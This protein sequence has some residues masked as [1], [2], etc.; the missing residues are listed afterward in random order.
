MVSLFCFSSEK[1][2]AATQD[3]N[4]DDGSNQSSVT[5]NTDRPDYVLEDSQM[6]Q[7][8]IPSNIPAVWHPAPDTIT[9][10]ALEKS[11]P[12]NK[13]PKIPDGS[14]SENTEF[15]DT[16]TVDGEKLIVHS[17][18]VKRKRKR[19]PMYIPNSQRHKASETISNE[20]TESEENYYKF[21][22]H[23]PAPSKLVEAEENNYMID[24]NVITPSAELDSSFGRPEEMSIKTEPTDEPISECTETLPVEDPSSTNDGISQYDLALFAQDKSFQPSF[25]S[26]LNSVI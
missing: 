8:D 19:K 14:A 15:S 21:S 7:N 6:S 26:K 22:E 20:N 5:Q 18:P 1:H 12:S 23:V 25:A 13:L 3:L 16:L 9:V 24:K 11:P 2:L 4:N 10:N 17:N